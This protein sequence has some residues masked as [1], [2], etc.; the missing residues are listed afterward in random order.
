MKIA[1]LQKMTL[2]DY[3]GKVACTVFLSGCNFACPFCHNAELLGGEVPPLMDD[4]DLLAFLEKRRG[5]LDAVCITGGEPT[6]HP[7]LGD[8][9]RAIKDMGYLVKLDTNGYRPN[10]LK[11]L[12]ADGLLDYVAMDIKNGPDKYAETAGIIAVDLTAIEESMTFLLTGNLDYEFRT[13][14]AAQLHSENSIREMTNWVG[15]LV[16]GTKAKRF[17]LQ[18]FVD[19]DTVEYS[20]L[21]APTQDELNHYIL[22]LK[23][24]AEMA[25]IRGQ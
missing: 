21:S 4:Q 6:L 2:L 5:M 3:P 18:P 9:M 16:P 1:G 20:G 12:A 13:T 15:N 14:V 10:I 11:Q 23:S 7:G 19:R 17:F 25:E 24:I 22:C 8:L